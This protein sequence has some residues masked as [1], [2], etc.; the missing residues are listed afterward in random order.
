ME[1]TGVSYVMSPTS[2][3]RF[4]PKRLCVEELFDED[5]LEEMIEIITDCL[6]KTGWDAL[7]PHVKDAL[8]ETAQKDIE[9]N[10]SE[11]D[12][13]RWSLNDDNEGTFQFVLTN[14]QFFAVP[15][16][17][18]EETD[19]PHPLLWIKKTPEPFDELTHAPT[20]DWALHLHD[21]PP[22]LKE[23]I[24]RILWSSMPVQA[25]YNPPPPPK[26]GKA[27]APPDK[28]NW[29][30]IRVRGTA[31][32]LFHETPRRVHPHQGRDDE[33]QPTATHDEEWKE[34]LDETWSR[35][36]GWGPEF[37][38][39]SSL[40][41]HQYNSGYDAVTWVRSA[42]CSFRIES[43]VNSA[44]HPESDTTSTEILLILQRL[45]R[46]SLHA[47]RAMWRADHGNVEEALTIFEGHLDKVFP[48]HELVV[49]FPAA[50]VLYF[51]RTQC[52]PPS[53]GLKHIFSESTVL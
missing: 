1:S 31:K 40:L 8:S 2:L 33:V 36:D 5:Q 46:L 22:P 48:A 14:A 42:G 12:H 6:Y 16:P 4:L 9:D 35:V 19:E 34:D 41:W 25:L 11:S 51:D 37:N 49:S 10:R 20:E 27:I 7:P 29:V 13:D 17:D 39:E 26:R 44:V 52:P 38:F 50:G 21:K 18:A 3:K 24:A 15:L 47:Q 32:F 45:N 30:R 53:D 43:A 23:Q 28:K